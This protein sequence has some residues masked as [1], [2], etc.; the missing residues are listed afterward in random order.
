VE[1][2]G[3]KE[4]GKMRKRRKMQGNGKEKKDW[5]EEENESLI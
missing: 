2:K 3:E 4:E 5:G 1:K